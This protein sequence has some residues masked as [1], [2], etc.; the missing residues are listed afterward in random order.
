MS[1]KLLG[2]KPNLLSTLEAQNYHEAFPIQMEAIPEILKGKDVLGIAPTGSGKT[3][4]FVLPILQLL[5]GN[6]TVKNRHIKCLTLVPTRELAIQI[7]Q[8]FQTLSA[9]LTRRIKSMAIYGGVSKN[10]Q[11]IGLQNVEILIATPGRLLDLIESKAVHITET[12][13]L[14]MDEA[15]KLFSMGFQDEI[16]ALLKML[17]A[18]RQN[19]LF[20][21]TLSER[22]EGLKTLLLDAPKVITIEADEDSIDLINQIA[23]TVTE[24]RKGPLLRYLIKHHKMTQVLVF[25]SSIMQ[26]NRVVNKLAKNRIHSATIHSKMSMGARTTAL[27]NFKE[28][29]LRVLVATDIIARGIDISFLPIVINYELP[30]SPKDFIHRIGRTG[31]AGAEGQAISLITE[32]EHHH[33]KVIQKKL[34]SWVKPEETVDW[35]LKGF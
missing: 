33:F 15:D 11:M 34:G 21:A 20:S 9:Q 25:T 12:S 10:P 31:R 17:P 19:L 23:Y 1:F 30:R 14:V 13:I 6:A 28:G 32:Q 4:S 2:L 22:V 16:N 27:R 24:E 29:N 3:A 8:A 35:D 18:Q 5:E 26:A 7:H